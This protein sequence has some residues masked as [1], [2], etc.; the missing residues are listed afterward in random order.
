MGRDPDAPGQVNS[1][2]RGDLVV[3]LLPSSALRFTQ[4][5]GFV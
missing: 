1:K 5:S 3:L 2:G 4:S